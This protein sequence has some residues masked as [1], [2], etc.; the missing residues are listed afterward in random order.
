MEKFQNE[1]KSDSSLDEEEL[2]NKELL[3]EVKM[4]EQ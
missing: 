4:I 2:I 1:N 3:E